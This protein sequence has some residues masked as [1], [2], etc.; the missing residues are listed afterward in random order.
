VLRGAAFFDE[1]NNIQ[2]DQY[3]SSGLA[4]TAN[5][6]D[7]H[8]QGLEA[9]AAYDWPFGLSVQANALYSAP[10][11]TSVNRDFAAFLGSGLPGAPRWSGGLLVR[12]DRPL[13]RDLTLRLISQLGYVG[14]ARLTFDPTLSDR[15]DTVLNAELLAELVARRWSA[16][17]FVT[18][19][20]DSSGN[21]FAYGNP[22]TFGQVHQVTPQRPR[23]IGFRLAAGF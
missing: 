1:W 4:Y 15:T 13:P 6:G 11:F 5:V 10:K 2:S 12:Y 18:N 19:P 23:T 22:F 14:P 7:A 8:I 20:A 9:E 16:G 17:L 3:R 21:T